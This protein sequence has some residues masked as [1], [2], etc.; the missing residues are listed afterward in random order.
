MGW[1]VGLES[2]RVMAIHG[3]NDHELEQAKPYVI[4]PWVDITGAVPIESEISATANY[5]LLQ[6]R[7]GEEKV[8]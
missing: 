1:K 7:I 8:D 4:S 3:Y 5:S 2:Y 6:T